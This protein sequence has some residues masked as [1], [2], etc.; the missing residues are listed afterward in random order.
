M[1][2]N[3]PVHA[4]EARANPPVAL[5]W[6]LSPH[7]W[8]AN[9]LLTTAMSIP[10]T[11]ISFYHH[12]KVTYHTKRTSMTSWFMCPARKPLFATFLAPEEN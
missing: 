10:A 7:T 1:A 9:G 6:A 12:V 2:V 5:A 4:G 8:T 11:E 3:L